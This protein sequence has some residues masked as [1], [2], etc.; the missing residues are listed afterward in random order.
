MLLVLTLLCSNIFLKRAVPDLRVDVSP[1]PSPRSISD[2]LGLESYITFIVI[3][4]HELDKAAVSEDILHIFL[5][6]CTDRAG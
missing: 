6:V 3:A 5:S 4:Y 2:S 1:S